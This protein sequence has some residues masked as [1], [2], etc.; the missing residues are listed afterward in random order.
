MLGWIN[1]KKQQEKFV[2]N[3]LSEIRQSKAIMRYVESKCNPADLATRGLKPTELS[4]KAI[5]WEGP[6]F[7]ENEESEWPK[8]TVHGTQ[9]VS[10]ETPDL[11]SNATTESVETETLINA[12][13]FLTWKKLLR[14]TVVVL[15]SQGIFTQNARYSRQP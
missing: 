5:W 2:E 9:E 8:W 1:S 7:L 14:V 13:R 6:S 11:V 10:T 3:R 12:T 4:R 15:K